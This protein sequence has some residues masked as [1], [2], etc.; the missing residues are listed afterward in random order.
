MNV[1]QRTKRWLA[2]GASAA[3]LG[4]GGAALAVAGSGG[5]SPDPGELTPNS[6]SITVPNTP[7]PNEPNEAQETPGKEGPEGAEAPESAASEKAEDASEA[8]E[9]AQLAKVAKVDESQAKSAALSKVPGTAQK[10]ELGN[11]NGNVVWEV[12][13]KGDDGKTHEV[14]VDAGN[15]SV[16][17]AQVDDD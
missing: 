11:E 9:A 10:A 12:E 13:V 15:A 3:A 6:S 7:D 4:G 8:A 14:K 2:V 17:S 16:L 1:S 5:N